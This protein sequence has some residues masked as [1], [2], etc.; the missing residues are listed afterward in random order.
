M[1]LNF[2]FILILF[3]RKPKCSVASKVIFSILEG[4]FLLLRLFFQS[5]GIFPFPLICFPLKS[6]LKASNLR[7]RV[8]RKSRFP[9]AEKTFCPQEWSGCTIFFFLC[10]EAMKQGIFQKDNKI[11]KEKDKKTKNCTHTHKGIELD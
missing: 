8:I 6:I 2:R 9:S 10:P 7:A 5:T 3:I 4:P 11:E 1:G